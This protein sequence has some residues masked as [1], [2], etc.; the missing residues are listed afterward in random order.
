[1]GVMEK[2]RARDKS[3]NLRG[4]AKLFEETKL[5][6]SFQRLG[7]VLYGSGWGLPNGREYISCFIEGSVGN[8][9]IVVDVEQARGY[10][11]ARMLYAV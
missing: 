9:I 6:P 1:M 5:D 10:L 3:E 8:M 7:G 11:R 2:Y 4:I